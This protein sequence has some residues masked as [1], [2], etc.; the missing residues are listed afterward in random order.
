MRRIVLFG[1]LMTVG[2]TPASSPNLVTLITLT[3]SASADGVFVGDQF[4]VTATPLDA[5][6]DPVTFVP[7]TFTSSNPTVATISST[8]VVNALAA[9]TT[10]LQAQAGGTNS[11][12]YLITVDGN[13]TGRIVVTPNTPGVAA[14][15]QVQLT[16][17]VYTTDNDPARGKSVTWSTS[18]A[19]KATVDST[20]NVSAIAATSAVSICATSVDTPSIKGCATVTVN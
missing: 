9:G 2:C 5:N 18:D 15:S 13:V 11:G 8:G 20:G 1:L 16:A 17:T 7:V 3:N 12:Q 10:K 19:T 14:G 6:G 4:R